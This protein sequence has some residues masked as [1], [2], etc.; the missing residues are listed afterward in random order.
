M[1]IAVSRLEDSSASGGGGR[2][3]WGQSNHGHSAQDSECRQEEPGSQ[4]SPSHTIVLWSKMLT[5]SSFTAIHTRVLS[6]EDSCAGW[7]NRKI[8]SD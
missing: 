2:G 4:P 3:E 8:P 1:S 7:G 6:L 5:P